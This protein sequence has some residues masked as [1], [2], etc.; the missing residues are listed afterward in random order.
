[1]QNFDV[2]HNVACKQ[3]LLVMLPMCLALLQRGDTLSFVFNALC[4]IW[5]KR[6]KSCQRVEKHFSSILIQF[7]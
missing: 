7:R 3:D 1:M 5:I 2:Q 4:S 6:W